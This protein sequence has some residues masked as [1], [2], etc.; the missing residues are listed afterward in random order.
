ML[1]LGMQGC[2]VPSAKPMAE[3]AVTVF[4]SQLDAEQ[5][6]AIWDGADDLFRSKTSREEYAKFVGAVHKKL[7][8]VVNTTAQGWSVNYINFQTR[9]VLRQ[10]TQFANGSAN[11][12]FLYIV[13]GNSVKL[14]GYNISSNDL[15]TL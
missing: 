11:E 4:H 6:D 15:I 10:E 13:K 1:L 12:T 14:A 5:F 7:G 3:A 2:G 9:V 8:S